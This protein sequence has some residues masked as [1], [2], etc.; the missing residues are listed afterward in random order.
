MHE[1]VSNTLTWL[2]AHKKVSQMFFFA[3][4]FTNFHQIWRAAKAMNA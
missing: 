3:E 2:N 4:L 1:Q